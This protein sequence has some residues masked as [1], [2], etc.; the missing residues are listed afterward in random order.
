MHKCCNNDL[1][2]CHVGILL[3][4]FPKSCEKNNNANIFL[5]CYQLLS[6]NPFNDKILV[7]ISFF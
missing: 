3:A 5:N 4:I 1:K 2:L 6:D 7:M